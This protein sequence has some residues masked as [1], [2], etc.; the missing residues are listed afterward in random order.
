[1]IR[2]GKHVGDK[3]IVVPH[4]AV[5]EVSLQG[6]HGGLCEV[7]VQDV[8]VEEL[9]ADVDACHLSCSLPIA[10]LHGQCH[11]GIGKDKLLP[12]LFPSRFPGVMLVARLAQ[13]QTEFYQRSVAISFITV[14]VASQSPAHRGKSPQFPSDLIVGID[15]CLQGVESLRLVAVMFFERFYMIIAYIS[16]QTPFR[17]QLDILS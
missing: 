14:I 3:E 6:S 11:R 1:M 4:H 16:T 13:G 9:Y 8:P 2:M 5:G 15:T 10:F 12:F 17:R 7:R